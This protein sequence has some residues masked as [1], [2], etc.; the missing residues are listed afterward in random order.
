[1]CEIDELIQQNKYAELLLRQYA[2]YYHALEGECPRALKEV[3]LL[4]DWHSPFIAVNELLKR[5]DINDKLIKC[6]AK[7]EG[8]E[9][10]Y[11]SH[12]KELRAFVQECVNKRK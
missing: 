7:K 3:M 6:K 12:Y 10:V 5:I 1:M 11:K 2:P 8:V 4:N 9:V